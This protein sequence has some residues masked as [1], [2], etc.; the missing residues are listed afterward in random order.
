MKI[1]VPMALFSA[2]RVRISRGPLFF[3]LCAR[4]LW[5]SGVSIVKPTPASLV[6]PGG[7]QC[8]G[9]S[10]ARISPITMQDETRRL[11]KVRIGV[12]LLF[13][14]FRI[15]SCFYP[16]HVCVRPP[17]STL[18]RPLSTKTSGGGGFSTNWKTSGQ[19]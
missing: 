1:P 18:Y 4:A 7:K 13:R 3:L 17:R 11:L 19:R 15:H 2:F 10:L 16:L 5:C 9:P 8:F 12:K 6:I 14:F